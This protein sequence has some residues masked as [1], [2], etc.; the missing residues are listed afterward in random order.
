MLMNTTIPGQ[1]S[2]N[3]LTRLAE[4]AAAVPAN[5][6][7][8][9]VGSLYGLA[10]WHLA[11]NAAP[12]VTVFCID[13]WVPEQWIVDLVERPQNAPPFGRAAFQRYTADC[14]NIVMIQGYSPMVA[15]GWKLPVDLYVED[16]IHANPVLHANIAFWGDRVRPGGVVAGHDYTPLWPD[17]ISEVNAMAGRLGVAVNLAETLWWLQK[18]MR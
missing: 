7:I 18:P 6:I 5:G 16:A 12:G 13:P 15:R 11:R 14:D 17:V 4:L 2:T 10:S 8:V 1:M 3:E 9:E